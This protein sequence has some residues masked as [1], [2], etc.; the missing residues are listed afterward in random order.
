MPVKAGQESGFG[1]LP[2]TLP[3]AQKTKAGRQITEVLVLNDDYNVT[4]AY[5]TRVAAGSIAEGKPCINFT[6]NNAGGQ[7]FGELTGS[8]LPDKLSGFSYRLAIILDDEVY[9]APSIRSTIYEN[10]QIT[11]S[12][13]NEE[14]EISVNVLNAGSLPAKIRPVKK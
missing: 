11:G 1:Q 13:T 7:L 2:P 6:F 9:S 12:F 8:H 14:V 4:G 10:G 3:Y 5:L